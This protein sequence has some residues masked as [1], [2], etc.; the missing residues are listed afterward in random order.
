MLALLSSCSRLIGSGADEGDDFGGL[1]LALAPGAALA[2]VLA[3]TPLSS[4]TT[5]TGISLYFAPPPFSQRSGYTAR[6]VDVPLI[7]GWYQE[8]A[9]AGLPVKVRV[10]YI[11]SAAISVTVGFITAAVAAKFSH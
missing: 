6:V 11:T 4:P 9:P 8:R 10:S 7:K 1:P 2:P 3:G 5:A